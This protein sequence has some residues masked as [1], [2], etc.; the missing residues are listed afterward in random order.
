M[1]LF[2]ACLLGALTLACSPQRLDSFLYDPL[3]STTGCAGLSAP[4]CEDVFVDSTGGARVHVALAKASGMHA[5]VTMLYFHGQSNDVTSSWPRVALLAPLG[6]NIAAVDPRGYGLS[7]G[8]PSEPGIHDDLMAVWDALGKRPDLDVTKFVIYGRSLGAAFAT[9]LA[10]VRPPA[11][12]VTESAFASIADMVRDGAYVDLPP[13]FV[14]DSRW[15]NLAKIAHVPAPYLAFH[16]LADD[17]VRYQDSQGLTAAHAAA[18]PA[19]TTTLVLV[20]GANHGD[21]HGPPVTLGPDAYLG[22]LRTFFG[23]ALGF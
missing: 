5:D 14:A 10:A 13:G 15:D 12:L 20:P 23:P 1:K 19:V 22:D 21:A 6:V 17:Y 2:G 8:T 9:D 4:T 3:T 18:F 11:A 7:T 16:G